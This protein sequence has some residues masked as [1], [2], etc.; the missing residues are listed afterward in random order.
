MKTFNNEE[1]RRSVIQLRNEGK[2]IRQIASEL[3]V[4]S[5]TVIAIFKEEKTEYAREGLQIKEQNQQKVEQSNYTKALRHFKGGKS[6]LDVTIKLGIMAEEAKRAFIDFRDIEEM[7]EFRRDYESIKSYLPSILKLYR[8]THEKGLTV[9]NLLVA[10]DYASERVKAEKELQIA[11]NKVT[12]VQNRVTI[13]ENH[14]L[15]LK[16]QESELLWGK[17]TSPRVAKPPFVA[18]GDSPRR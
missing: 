1:K 16:K 14:I 13:L 10:I 9:E 3:H 6:L 7:D 15:E 11:T 18:L 8:K 5:R 12:I 17:P 4:S 2:S